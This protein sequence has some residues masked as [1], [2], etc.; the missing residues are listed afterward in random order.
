MVFEGS[1]VFDMC[2]NEL[3]NMCQDKRKGVH[4]EIDDA[5]SECNISWKGKAMNDEC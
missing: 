2:S 3:P 4:P 5:I 1:L